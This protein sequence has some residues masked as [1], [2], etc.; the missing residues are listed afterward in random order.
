MSEITHAV[1]VQ[2]TGIDE[3]RDI[4]AVLPRDLQRAHGAAARGARGAGY[5]EGA[6]AMAKA[7]ETQPERWKRYH[8]IF[9]SVN[10]GTQ[11]ARAWMGLNPYPEKNDDGQVEYVA[12]PDDFDPSEEVGEVMAGAYLR[13]LDS[14]VQKIIDGR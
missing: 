4:A 5:T 10:P 1:T 12:F 14:Q 11:E 7:T 8:R 6:K 9:T 13:I 2:V 3:I